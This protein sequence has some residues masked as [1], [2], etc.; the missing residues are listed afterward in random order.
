MGEDGGIEVGARGWYG[1]IVEKPLV[2]KDSRHFHATPTP[3]TRSG[4]AYTV[5]L[6]AHPEH[7]LA[8]KPWK[9]ATHFGK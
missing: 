6:V 9:R 4:F 3:V 1:R 7:G 8:S 2:L 5:E